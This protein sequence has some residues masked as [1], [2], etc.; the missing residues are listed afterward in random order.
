LNSEKYEIV[1]EKEIKFFDK[2]IVI[3]NDVSNF[4]ETNNSNL[5]SLN[6]FCVDIVEIE[7]KEEKEEK[8]NR[9]NVVSLIYHYARVR[10]FRN[11]SL[12]QVQY[13][14]VFKSIRRLMSKLRSRKKKNSSF[15]SLLWF[16]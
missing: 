3:K 9:F 1:R 4:R 5:S 7:E 16:Y 15:V 6:K 14:E 11:V 13:Y 12:Q 2:K 10:N 8:K